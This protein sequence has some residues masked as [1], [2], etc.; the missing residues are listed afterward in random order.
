MNTI[1]ASWGGGLR[2][3]IERLGQ[4]MSAWSTA[5]KRQREENMELKPEVKKRLWAQVE[6]AKHGRNMSPT[7]TTVE[8]AI[9]YLHEETRKYKERKGG[10]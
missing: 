8:D 4:R 9:A 5:K 6:D 1:V 7:F 10:Q 2:R 3:R